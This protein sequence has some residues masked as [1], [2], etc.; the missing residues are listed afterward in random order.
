[1]TK[2]ERLERVQK[3]LED[4]AEAANDLQ[5]AALGT[6]LDEEVTA[7]VD[8][9]AHLDAVTRTRGKLSEYKKSEELGYTGLTIINW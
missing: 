6:E 9:E 8:W 1:M 7:V 3:L 5:N 4:F 2:I